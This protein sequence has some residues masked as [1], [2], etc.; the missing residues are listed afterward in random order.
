[1][2]RRV[3]PEEAHR[4][5]VEEGYALLDVRSVVEFEAGHPEGA[6]NVPWVIL[7]EHGR[8]PNP[9]FVRVVQ[10]AFPDRATKLVL[11]CLAGH[12]SLEALHAL[13]AEGYTALVDQRAGWG[14]ERDAFGQL[15]EKGWSQRGLPSAT[16][17]GDERSYA[18]L[19]R[20]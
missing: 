15:T 16:G 1:M 17:A 11:S 6:W 5:V 9:D 2:A 10:A 3:G 7:D 20:R 12:R 8:R 4:L 18:A 13:E 19:S 14:G